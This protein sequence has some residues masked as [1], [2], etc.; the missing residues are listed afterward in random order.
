MLIIGVQIEVN[1]LYYI[2][3]DQ[4][5]ALYSMTSYWNQAPT[6]LNLPLSP[7][8]KAKL[9]STLMNI[10]CL[11]LTQD[12]GEKLELRERHTE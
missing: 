7:V 8:I 4:K 2:K 9:A 10:I 5:A 12:C 11:K 1:L 3:K 6:L